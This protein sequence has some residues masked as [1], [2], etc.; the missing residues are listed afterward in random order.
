[1]KK[2]ITILLI[3]SLTV[4]TNAVQPSNAPTAGTLLLNAA[5]YGAIGFCVFDYVNNRDRITTNE[6]GLFLSSGL[7]P[8]MLINEN[9]IDLI[10]NTGYAFT[11]NE[12]YLSYE[13]FDAIDFEFY[14]VGYNR[15]IVDRKLSLLI[16]SEVGLI[17]SK[18]SYGAN[19]MARLIL[20]KNVSL[21]LNSNIKTRPDISKDYIGSNYFKLRIKL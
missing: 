1:M 6:Q 5:F 18:L 10:I 13:N 17:E 19:V 12:I 21:E 11:R 16:G 20:S 2:L 14:G 3:L 4:S 9:V 7:D 15:A 8:K